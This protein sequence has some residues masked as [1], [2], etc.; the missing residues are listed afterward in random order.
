MAKKTSKTAK[1]KAST[2][3]VW[4]P[5]SVLADWKKSVKA[6]LGTKRLGKPILD[7]YE[8]R[9]LKKIETRLKTNDYNLEGAGTRAVAKTIGQFCKALT[10]GTEVSR[11]VFDVV[12]VACQLHPRCPRDGSGAGKWCDI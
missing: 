8:P 9:L 6:A 4:T 11:G 12:W 10:V 1:K 2:R 5:E 3:K 7:Y